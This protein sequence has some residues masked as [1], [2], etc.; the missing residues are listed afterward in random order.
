M[1]PTF[2]TYLLS[3]VSIDIC[4]NHHRLQAGALI[5][6]N[7]FWANMHLLFYSTDSAS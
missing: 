6:G 5:N 3:F 7:I 2:L 1:L 4:W